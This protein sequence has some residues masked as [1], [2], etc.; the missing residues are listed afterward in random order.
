M[1]TMKKPIKNAL[2]LA[3]MT[4]MAGHMA[5][6][7]GFSLYTESSAAAI[8]NYAAGIAAEG[9]DASIGWYNPAGLVLMKQTQAV[10]GGVGVFPSVRL[11]GTSTYTTNPTGV[12]LQYVETYRNLQGANSA[13]VPSLHYVRPLGERVVAGLSIVSPFGLATNYHDTSPVRY[14]G[15]LSQLETVNVSPELGGKLTD[16]FSIG[17]GIDLQYARVK[18]NRMLGSPA[19]MSEAYGLPATTLDSITYN[20]GDSFAVGFHAGVLWMMNDEHSRLGL[21]YQSGMNHQFSGYSQL[22]GRLADPTLNLYLP[23]EADPYSSFRSNMLTSNNISLP[24][25][26][27]LSAYQD[28]NPQWAL[29]GSLVYT[30]WST[31][32][33]ITL[34]NAAVGVPLR[35]GSG[36]LLTTANATT[37][38]NY[39]NTWRA[40]LG[41][42]YHVTSAWLLRV[43]GGYDQTPTVTAERDVRLPDCD[44]FALSVGTHYQLRPSIGVDLGY[45]HLFAVNNATINNT[46]AIG[47]LSHYQVAAVAKNSAD[48]VGAQVV[49]QMDA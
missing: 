29:L 28:I 3:M 48:L 19:L 20:Q 33:A 37:L 1:D 32:K 10:L 27:T 2:N 23:T 47:T 21:N 43:G 44:R 41:M 6:A 46:Q 12:P 24:N 40:A 30:G 36:T 45:T 17:A 49:W 26:V 7:G 34:N 35:D 15:T 4:M 25:I 5:Y 42:N 31:F 14:E 38:E 8:G 22:T 39:R 13:A 9:A 11:S 16:N 18:F